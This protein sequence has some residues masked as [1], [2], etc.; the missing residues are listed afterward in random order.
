MNRLESS[1]ALL[2]ERA[3]AWLE[4]RAHCRETINAA[5][6]LSPRTLHRYGKMVAGLLRAASEAK[7]SPGDW[8]AR[9]PS[10]V[11]W[12]LHASAFRW[13]CASLLLASIKAIELS[14]RSGVPID[15]SA[16][17][18]DL[19]IVAEVMGQLDQLRRPAAARPKPYREK[20]R[21]ESQLPLDWRKRSIDLVPRKDR[22]AF[23]VL[24]ASGCR[25]AELARGVVCQVVEVGLHPSPVLQV[26]VEIKGSKCRSGCGHRIRSLTL[27]GTHEMSQL[28]IMAL[29]PGDEMALGTSL[30]V[31]M[32]LRSIE[33]VFERLARE[34]WPEGSLRVTPYSFR[35]AFRRDCDRRSMSRGDIA[36]AMGH[37]SRDSS[38]SYGKPRKIR[39]ALAGMAFK[40]SAQT[41]AHEVSLRA[42]AKSRRIDL[43]LALELE[44]EI[45]RRRSRERQLEIDF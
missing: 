29:F 26:S 15:D 9:Y 23:L 43:Q 36:L 28:L 12:N 14:T 45:D 11:R 25:P 32:P 21:K 6:G 30:L 13:H 4:H 17:R 7:L 18:G 37:Q 16:N 40:G 24:A 44:L 10:L 34:P 3:R 38:L 41:R 19:L 31:S 35:Y 1:N 39:P 2:L 33:R 42:S 27:D 20:A 8:M 22:A 5:E